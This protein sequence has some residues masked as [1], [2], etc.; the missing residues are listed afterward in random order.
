VTLT[1]D[2]ISVS[3]L[4]QKNHMPARIWKL[5]HKYLR[6]PQLRGRS[7]RVTIDSYTEAHKIW[8]ELVAEHPGAVGL[9][10]EM[11]LAKFLTELL[12]EKESKQKK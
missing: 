6:D 7:L 8:E 12:I 5:F 3:L 10:F 4:S 1:T 9:K 11:S 2:L